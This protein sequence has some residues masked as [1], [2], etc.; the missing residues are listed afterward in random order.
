MRSVLSLVLVAAAIEF[1]FA[2]DAWTKKDY[3]HWSEKEC[4]QVLR[5]SPWGKTYEVKHTV[6]RQ[7]NRQPFLNGRDQ[8]PNEKGLPTQNQEGVR[9]ETITYHINFRSALPVR[10]AFIRS[11]LLEA[12]YDDMDDSHRKAADERAAR[13]VS[14]TFP[15]KIIV[16]VTYES[17]VMDYDRQLAAYWQSRTAPTLREVISLSGP[18]G[19]RVPPVEYWVGKGGQREFQVSFPRKGIEDEDLS[20]PLMLEFTSPVGPDSNQRLVVKFPIENM[21]I[22][23]KVQY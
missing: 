7:L 11:S 6:M 22:D 4:R 21:K 16:D 19:D 9:D 15:D 1:A 18:D 14:V 10:Q 13:F 17:N 23:G 20:K 3:H 5:D 2:S 8:N 12:H